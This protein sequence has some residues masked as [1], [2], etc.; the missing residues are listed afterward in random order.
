[1]SRLLCLPVSRPFRRGNCFAARALPTAYFIPFTSL[2]TAGNI[3]T[4][5]TIPPR[6]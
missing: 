6:W 3:L 2:S 4:S 5:S 1:M